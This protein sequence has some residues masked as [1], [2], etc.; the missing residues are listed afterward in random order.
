MI[1]TCI[2]CGRDVYPM[3]DDPNHLYGNSICS[4]ECMADAYKDI[5]EALMQMSGKQID[6]LIDISSDDEWR[7]LVNE[8]SKHVKQEEIKAH[9]RDN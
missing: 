9:Y 8:L 5:I 4:D 7:D 1:K 6:T 3:D 2:M